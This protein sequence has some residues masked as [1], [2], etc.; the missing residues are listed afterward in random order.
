MSVFS[1][2]RETLR[3]SADV[4]QGEAEIPEVA[5]GHAAQGPALQGIEGGRLHGI[6]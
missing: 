3:L 1:G 6:R 5:G 2:R 4:E